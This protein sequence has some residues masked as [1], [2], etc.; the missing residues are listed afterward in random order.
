VRKL[1]IL[2]ALLFIP[3]CIFAQ[4]SLGVRVNPFFCNGN[5]ATGDAGNAFELYGFI[6]PPKIGGIFKYKFDENFALHTEINYNLAGFS[7]QVE[8]PSFSLEYIEIPL[9]FQVGGKTKFRGFAE[10][11]FSPKF[12]LRGRHYLSHAH[13]DD[14][15]YYNAG[16]YFY[17]FMVTADIGAGIM[18]DAWKLT[19]LAGIRCGYDIIPIG[20]NIYDVNDIKWTFDNMR[21]LHIELLIFGVMYNF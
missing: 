8:G 9:L 12:L 1:L 7:Y 2:A 21:F 19:F 13:D 20:K 17:P 10:A 15:D 5:R 11:G 18:L 6:P 3:S 14:G 16:D 4:F